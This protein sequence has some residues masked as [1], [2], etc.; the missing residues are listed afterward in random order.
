MFEFLF[1]SVPGE[2]GKF[3]TFPKL[4]VLTFAGNIEFAGQVLPEK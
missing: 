2:I 4:F 3:E 1:N